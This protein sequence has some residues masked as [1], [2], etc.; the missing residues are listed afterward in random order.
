MGTKRFDKIVVVDL[1]AT[2]WQPREEQGD[3]PSEIIEIGVCVIDNKTLDIS[4]KT[5]YIVKPK[6]S[7]I[8]TFCTELTGLTWDKVKGGM[9]FENACNKLAK[10]FGSRNRVWASWGDYDRVHFQKECAAKN[11]RYPFGRSHINASDLFTLSFGET[12]R[13]NVEEALGMIGYKFEGRPHC[14]ADDAWNIARILKYLLEGSRPSERL[15]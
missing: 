4:R 13:I 7:T 14:G 12:R 8:S 2:C 6:Y 15:A 3:Q 9:P 1:E 10:E 5:S 11:A